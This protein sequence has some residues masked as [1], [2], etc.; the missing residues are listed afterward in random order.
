MIKWIYAISLLTTRLSATNAWEFQF[1]ISM[2]HNFIIPYYE[3]QNFNYP[4]CERIS[5]KMVLSV[6]LWQNAR[7]RRWIEICYL[8]WLTPKQSSLATSNNKRRLYS[9]TEKFLKLCIYKPDARIC[10]VAYRDNVEKNIKE[11]NDETRKIVSCESAS[12]T[13]NF[14]LHLAATLL[15]RQMC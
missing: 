3:R 15:L 2:R 11:N 7:M 12:R 9:L 1:S 4:P 10:N 5:F 8:H 13:S 14:S 6:R